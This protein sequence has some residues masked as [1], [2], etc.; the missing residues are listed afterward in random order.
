VRGQTASEQILLGK[1]RRSIFNAM[2]VGITRGMDL[3]SLAFNLVWKSAC[4]RILELTNRVNHGEVC[5]LG[6]AARRGVR[7]AST[8]L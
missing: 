7:P 5:S 6:T 1:S 3:V 4:L 8:L 2:G